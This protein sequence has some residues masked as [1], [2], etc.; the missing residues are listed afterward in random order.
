MEVLGEAIVDRILT[1]HHSKYAQT[2]FRIQ[3]LLQNKTL[4]A[5]RHLKGFVC[6]HTNFQSVVASDCP[7]RSDERPR[8]PNDNYF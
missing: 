6:R 8:P 3:S 2:V 4:P 1:F 7:T 5:A